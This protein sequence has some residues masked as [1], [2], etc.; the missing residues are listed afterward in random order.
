MTCTCHRTLATAEGEAR[1]CDR[2]LECLCGGHHFCHHC[3]VAQQRPGHL[4]KV[5]VCERQWG[6]V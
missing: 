4:G 2:E 1:A 3:E 6:R 5:C